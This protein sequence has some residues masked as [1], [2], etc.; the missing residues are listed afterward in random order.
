MSETLTRLKAA[1]KAWQETKGGSVEQ[2]LELFADQIDFR[3]LADG[4]DNL[5]FTVRRRTKDELRDYFFAV[6]ADWEMIHYT[7]GY[8]VEEGDRIVMMG[9]MAWRNRRT[10]ASFE[11]VKA[12]FWRFKDGKAVEFLEMYDTSAAQKCA[13]R[14][15]VEV[16]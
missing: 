2:W 8:F 1:C 14:S 3:S 13:C 10:K 5:P 9:S 15:E 16:G 7:P 11:S 12:D 6:A 4:R